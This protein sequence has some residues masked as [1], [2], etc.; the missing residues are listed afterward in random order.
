[1]LTFL[2]KILIL[3]KPV[4]NTA[5]QSYMTKS[6]V[7]NGDVL[8][9]ILW[10]HLYTNSTIKTTIKYRYL[11]KSKSKRKLSKQL[12]QQPKPTIPKTPKTETD[13]P[14]SRSYEMKNAKMTI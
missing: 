10:N 7:I 11:L 6:Q 4:L 12:N 9:Y 1:M 3:P 13:R 2:V 14:Y 8:A 5:I